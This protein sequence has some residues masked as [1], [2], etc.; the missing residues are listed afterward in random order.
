MAALPKSVLK[1]WKNR[2]DAVVL[3]TVDTK[4]MPNA[5][6]ATCV[7]LVGEDTLVVA[8]NY[9]KKTRANIRAGSPGSLLFITKGGD[10]YQIKGRIEYQTSGPLFDDMK[11]W[12]PAQHPGRA[13]AILRV[14]R[15]FRG[16]ERL[17]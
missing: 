7:R 6:Y 3:A 2:E 10:S 4:G 13:A 9:F 8:D 15:V 1:S 16:A 12:N 14:R 5:I 11:K 17:V